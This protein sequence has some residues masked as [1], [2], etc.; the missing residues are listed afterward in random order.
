M[1][2]RNRF[3]IFSQTRGIRQE[4][5][6]VFCSTTSPISS[7]L[8]KSHIETAPDKLRASCRFLPSGQKR[9]PQYNQSG[10]A[11]QKI[12]PAVLQQKY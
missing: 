8:G 4:N 10:L 6:P 5:I 2:Q 1:F 12:F 3:N 11:L 7:N 9:Q